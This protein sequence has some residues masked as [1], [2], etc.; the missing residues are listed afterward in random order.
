MKVAR[1]ITG[2]FALAF[3]GLVLL[4]GHQVDA[5]GAALWIVVWV[6]LVVIDRVRTTPR[7]PRKEQIK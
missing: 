4:T 6:V 1:R 2:S 7:S 3:I 5:S